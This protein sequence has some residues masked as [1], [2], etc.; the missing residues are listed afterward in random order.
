MGPTRVSRSTTRRAGRSAVRRRRRLA[1]SRSGERTRRCRSRTFAGIAEVT[2]EPRLY[3]FHATLKPPMRLADGRRLG[4]RRARRRG[5]LADRIA[6]FDLPPLAVPDV[7]GFL[8]LRE[9]VPSRAVAGAGRCLRRSSSIVCA[10]R[11]PTTELARRR[12]G[13]SDAA[14]GRDAGALG[15]SL[16]VRHLVLPHDADAPADRRREAACSCR[17]PRPISRARSPCRGA[18]TTSACSCSPRRAQ[19]FVIRGTPEAARLSAAT[20]RATPSSSEP[21]FTTV[22]HRHVVRHRDT[23]RQPCR[24]VGRALAAARCQPCREDVGR[25]GH[26]DHPHR[27]ARAPP[28]R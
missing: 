1:R 24:D 11:R 28:R 21:S 13:E 16:R 15:L 19:P 10:R 12:R 26:L 5:E 7:F 2:A 25:R 14:A 17:R 3:G 6:P 27:K 8:A 23:A 9:T 4:R 18:S 22:S 20:K